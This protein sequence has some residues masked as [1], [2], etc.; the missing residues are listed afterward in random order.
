MTQFADD[1]ND[2]LAPWQNADLTNFNNAVASMFTQ[3]EELAFDPDDEDEGWS[4]LF[5]VDRCPPYAL[6][7]L[8]QLVG[9]RLPVGL[10]TS[11]PATARTLI[12]EHPNWKRGTYSPQHHAD[13]PIVKA[14]QRLL[15]GSKTVIVRERDG[16][17]GTDDAYRLTVIVYNRETTANA[18]TYSRSAPD[19]AGLYTAIKDVMNPGILNLVVRDGQDW[20][21]VK[22][23]HPNWTDVKNKYR[24]WAEV[25]AALPTA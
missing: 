5:D 19:P 10:A 9:M 1:L 11:D 7:Y 21:S 6:D 17:N 25:A 3:V 8:A 13:S 16:V 12:K 24:S 22:S 23:I 20:Q 15:T 2:A 18:G 4:A 14:A